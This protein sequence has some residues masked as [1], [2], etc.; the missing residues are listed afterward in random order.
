MYAY[1]AGTVPMSTVDYPGKISFVIF[2]FFFYF[3]CP[4]CY[5][6]DYLDFKKDF[7]QNLKHTKKKIYD[8]KDF[9]DA[10]VLSGGEACIQTTA[11]LNLARFT[12]S[13]GLKLGLETNGSKPEVIHRLLRE[14]LIDFVGIDVK[15]PLNEDNFQKLTNCKTF[16]RNNNEV[17][18]S[19]KKTHNLLK[20]SNILVEARTT[21]IPQLNDN[22][23][24]E[25]AKT[26][27]EFT[28]NWKLQQFKPDAGVLLDKSYSSTKPLS[29]KEMFEL[30]RNLLRTYP[31]LKIKVQAN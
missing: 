15:S 10:V 21:I 19:I 16:F 1:I 17:I 5:N 7:Q 3:R 30:K 6:S 11:V 20:N 12:K 14:D 22:R 4:Y 8:N 29:K 25:I 18:E 9:L 27:L 13:I 24:E 23:I 26:V 2:F 31:D 28:R